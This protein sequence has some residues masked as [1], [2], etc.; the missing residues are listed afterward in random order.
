MKLNKQMR[1]EQEIS[2]EVKK[3]ALGNIWQE[4]EYDQDLANLI[5]RQYQFPDLI[6]KV[7]ASRVDS[8]ESA[9]NFINSSLKNN[10]SD[11]FKLLDMDKAAS[12]IAEMILGKKKIVI[13]GDYDVDGATSSALLKNY[14]KLLGNDASIYI[15]DRMREGYGPNIAAFEKLK[16]ENNDLVITVDCGIASHEAINRANE[17]NLDVIVIDHHIGT[18]NLPKALAVVNP[19]RFDETSDLGYCAAVGVCFLVTIAVNK[20][21]REKGYF[22]EIKEPNLLDLLDIVALGTVCD[23]V[24][25]Q[26][27]NRAFV[28]Q[29]LKKINKS[30]NPGL[31]KLIEIADINEEITAYHLGFMLG[32]RIN[33]GGRV[34]QSHFGSF[35]LSN[36]RNSKISSTAQ[37]LN[38]YNNERKA[39]ETDC[40]EQAQQ[41]CK[42]LQKHENN[43]ILLAQENWHPGVIGIVASRIKDKYYKPTAIIA[44]DGEVATASCRSITNVDFGAAIVKAKEAGLLI[45]GGGHKMAAGFKVETKK[46]AELEKFLNDQLQ[47]QVTAAIAHKTFKIDQYCSISN[48]NVAT[49]KQMEVMAP[50]GMKNPEPRFALQNCNIINSRIIGNNHVKLRIAQQIGGVYGQSIDAVAW[51]SVDTEIGRILLQEKPRNISIAGTIK[52]NNWQERENLQFFIEDVL[53]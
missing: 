45:A 52:I 47:G 14:F 13:F 15:P 27:L 42:E 29:G 32:P 31:N 51:R 2:S 11:P 5:S 35:L 49:I 26:G 17:I 20:I 9:E 8:I 53:L 23:V 37:M 39:I 1:K 25:L 16:Q 12:H 4:I 30:Q 50:F 41:L 6:A 28:R 44:I 22:K 3:S 34:G 7:I 33:A 46:I 21:L 18:E 38:Q 40:L 24:P 36:E 19:N 10:L 43:I 48:I